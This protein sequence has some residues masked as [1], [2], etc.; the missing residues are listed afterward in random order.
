VQAAPDGT[1]ADALANWIPRLVERIGSDAD[2]G[3]SNVTPEALASLVALVSAKAV[4]RDAARGV[5][6]RLV[7][8]GGDPAAIVEAEGLQ[9][10]TGGLTE[11]VKAAIAADPQ[12][13]AK[14]RAGN[15]KAMGPLVGFVMRKTKGRA[16]GGEVTRLIREQVLA[17]E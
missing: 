11:F 12:A 6:T 16:D 7:A 2:P 10:I 5:L 9:A 1:E 14:V 8:E 3:Q 17:G 13:A 4:T 15:M